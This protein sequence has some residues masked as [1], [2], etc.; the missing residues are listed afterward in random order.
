MRRYLRSGPFAS[1]CGCGPNMMA[2]CPSPRSWR[3]PV[4]PPGPHGSAQGRRVASLHAAAHAMVD[5]AWHYS[6][7]P[8]PRGYSYPVKRSA[9]AANPDPLT[10]SP[11]GGA[12]RSG[13]GRQPTSRPPCA[14]RRCRPSAGPGRRCGRRPRTPTRRSSGPGPGALA[15]R[16]RCRRWWCYR[17]LQEPQ[18]DPRRLPLRPSDPRCSL[19]AGGRPD[20]L[21]RLPGAVPA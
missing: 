20:R 15:P 11:G 14:G 19:H 5:T 7:S 3:A 9:I 13:S 17:W 16:R 6:K 2:S 4:C 10:P 21:R 1:T 12:R 18:L 8:L